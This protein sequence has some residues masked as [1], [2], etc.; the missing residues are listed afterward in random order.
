VA[1]NIPPYRDPRSG[2]N[3]QTDR[4]DKIFVRGLVLDC[5]IGAYEEERGRKQRVRFSVELWLYPARARN[6]DDVARVVS[7]DGI[8]DAIRAVTAGGHINLVE[9]VAERIAAKCLAH[10]RAAKVRVMVEKLD[11]VEG[12]SLG[13]EIERCKSPSA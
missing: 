3:R 12:A 1:D 7:Y 13:V 5:E 6:N 11:R 2:R 8:V 9:T 4:L 10:R